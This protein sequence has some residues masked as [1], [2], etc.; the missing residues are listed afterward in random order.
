MRCL[1]DH[2]EVDQLVG[3]NFGHALFIRA[4]FHQFVSLVECVPRLIHCAVE[5]YC[6]TAH[7][8][9]VF[10]CAEAANS[11][12]RVHRH[13]RYQGWQ[14]PDPGKGA[15]RGVRGPKRRVLLR[16]VVVPA[17]PGPKVRSA[18]EPEFLVSD[19]ELLAA[20]PVRCRPDEREEV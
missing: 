18:L 6:A 9:R 14:A 8:T 17:S 15:R 7:R 16:A 5:S 20:C 10:T 4:R 2:R 3:R 12:P 11:S 1:Q 19:A 13:T